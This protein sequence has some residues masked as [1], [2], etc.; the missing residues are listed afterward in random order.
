MNMELIEKFLIDECGFKSIE[1]AVK[2]MP[3]INIYAFVG[4]VEKKNKE[5]KKNE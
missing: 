2:N 5:E 3:R 4:E 1:D